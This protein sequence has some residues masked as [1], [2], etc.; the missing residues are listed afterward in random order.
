MKTWKPVIGYE[1]EY[2][3]SD[4][5]DIKRIKSGKGAVAGRLLRPY[6]NPNGYLY[7]TLTKNCIQKDF[8]L[9]RIVAAAFIGKSSSQINHKDGNKENNAVSNLE[10]VSPRENLIHATRILHKR[11]GDK[12]WN[13]RLSEAD[14]IVI[15]SLRNSGL[16]H[17]QIANAFKVSRTTIS[18]IFLCRKWKHLHMPLVCGT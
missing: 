3:V 14:V 15:L 11:R 5:G 13:S 18:E 1:N 17:Q 4:Y 7:V 9:H 10:Y 6:L 12:H 2:E 16:T 8:L